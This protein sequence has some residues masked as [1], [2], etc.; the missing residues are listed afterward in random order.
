MKKLKIY[1]DTSVISHLL[2][3]DTP[4]KMDET[5]KLWMEILK[6]KY[7]V[8]ISD[9]TFV[10]LMKCPEPKLTLLL[11][12]LSKIDYEE[13]LETEESIDLADQYLKYGILNPKSR[14]DCRHISVATIIGCYYIVS[15]N[16]KHF[17]NMKTINKVQALNKLLDYDSI[18]II[19]PSML[20]EGDEE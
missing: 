6:G 15:W 12:Q 1:L 7:K 17:L 18:S 3:E 5:K 13:I 4:E 9:L 16:F 8:F 2:A 11:E 10:E 19:P 20:M 14:D